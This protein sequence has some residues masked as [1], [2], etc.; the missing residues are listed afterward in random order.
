MAQLLRVAAWP[1]VAASR[2]TW[3]VIRPSVLAR[4]CGRIDMESAVW[5]G[6]C[7]L[8]PRRGSLEPGGGAHMTMSA[9]GPRRGGWRRPG[10][11]PAD[12]AELR[13]PLP[14]E[15]RLPVRVYA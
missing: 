3:I 10:S 5:W 9:L 6:V 12:L 2:S 7:A 13:G 4:T 14:G 8:S 11:L 1:D 15:V